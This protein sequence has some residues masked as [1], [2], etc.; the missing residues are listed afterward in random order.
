MQLGTFFIHLYKRLYA[1]TVEPIYESAE[2]G[3][4]FGPTDCFFDRNYTGAKSQSL[5]KT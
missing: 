4:I 1:Q 5:R 3:F 2:S